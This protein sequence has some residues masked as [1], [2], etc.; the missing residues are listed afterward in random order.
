MWKRG[1][2]LP[3]LGRRDSAG[4]IKVDGRYL[5]NGG[6]QGGRGARSGREGWEVP[7]NKNWGGFLITERLKW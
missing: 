1:K 2:W 4:V 5:F 7:P 6:F 3:G